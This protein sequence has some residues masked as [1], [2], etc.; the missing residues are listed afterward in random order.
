M[1]GR[2]CRRGVNGEGTTVIE[3]NIV[4]NCITESQLML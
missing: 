2:F 4:I 1:Q 3:I